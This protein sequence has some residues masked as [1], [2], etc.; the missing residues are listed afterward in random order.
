MESA[1][2]TRPKIREA[3]LLGRRGGGGR[4]RVADG[5]AVDDE[6]DAAVALAAVGGVIRSDGLGLAEA[7][8]GDKRSRDAMLGVGL[9]LRIV[10]RRRHPSIVLVSASHFAG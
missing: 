2:T 1:A 3:L 7:P 4:G 10:A 8:G 6:L 9:A 5:V